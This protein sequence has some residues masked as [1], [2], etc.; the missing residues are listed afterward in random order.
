MRNHF[1]DRLF[2]NA[3]KNKKIFIIA[4][5]ISPVEVWKSLEKNIQIDL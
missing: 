3:K 4:A 1:A 2:Y 5:D